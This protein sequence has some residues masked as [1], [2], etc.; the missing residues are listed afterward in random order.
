[1]IVPGNLTNNSDW[2]NSINEYPYYPKNQINR[3]E[4]TIYVNH[5]ERYKFIQFE[6]KHTAIIRD[7]GHARAIRRKTKFKD[8]NVGDIFYKNLY[9][10]Y[11][12]MSQTFLPAGFA[13]ERKGKIIYYN[14][15]GIP[16]GFACRK[17]LFEKFIL[18]I[19]LKSK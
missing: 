12:G 1:M 3:K 19:L 11:L 13:I 17:V 9:W 2:L 6:L 18:G 8:I 4:N 15:P 14:M 16:D 7:R 5:S 10:K